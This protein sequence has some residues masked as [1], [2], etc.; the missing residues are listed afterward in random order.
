M[1]SYITHFNYDYREMWLDLWDRM[2]ARRNLDWTEYAIKL[3]AFGKFLFEV[4]CSAE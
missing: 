2:S 3:G 1:S 4:S